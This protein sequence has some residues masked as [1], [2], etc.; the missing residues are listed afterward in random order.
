VG[1]LVPALALAGAPFTS[2]ALA[3]V[4]LKSN[5]AFLPGI[6][7]ALLGI[8]LPLAAVGTTLKMA[9][10]LSLTWPRRAEPARPAAA[11]TWP[12]WLCLVA[13]VLAGVWL[14]PGAWGWLPDKLTPQ[15]LWLATWPLLVGGGLAALGA[16]LRR[17]FSGDPLRWLPAGDVGV[18]LEKAVAGALSRTPARTGPDPGP[19]LAQSSGP[20]GSDV[21]ARAAAIGARLVAVERKL[22]DWSSAGF[23]LLAVVAL[24]L[25]LLMYPASY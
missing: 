23:A 15:K 6:W 22:G 25:W 24:L 14:L 4:A 21:L 16:W 2:G 12:P 8:L 17:R 1:L 20:R 13:A 18:L 11:G 5:L 19:D 3:K 10:F 7:P 9:R